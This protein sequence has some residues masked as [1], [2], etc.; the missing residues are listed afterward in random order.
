MMARFSSYDRGYVLQTSLWLVWGLTLLSWV[1][2]MGGVAS[3]QSQ[4][5]KLSDTANGLAT[6][7]IPDISYAGGCKYLYQLW[8]FVWAHELVVLVGIGLAGAAGELY[9]TTLLWTALLTVQ[10]VLLIL[11]SNSFWY[12]KYSFPSST[13]YGKRIRT[14]VAGF[15]LV[16]IFNTTLL[17]NVALLDTVRPSG[18][19]NGRVYDT[20][21]AAVKPETSTVEDPMAVP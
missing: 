1:V 19:G 8:W 10:T 20:A 15:L 21:P 5:D 4:C 11:G 13:S 7:G 6:Q 9:S 14:S 16:A 3:L 18:G 17:C 12:Y 2:L